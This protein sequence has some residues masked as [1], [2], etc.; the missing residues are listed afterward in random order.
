MLLGRL[1][2]MAQASGAMPAGG[3]A[4][5]ALPR[6]VPPSSRLSRNTSTRSMPTPEVAPRSMAVPWITYAP[7]RM[8]A[9]GDGLATSSVMFDCDEVVVVV[10]VV[11]VVEVLGVTTGAA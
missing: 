3:A 6:K 9:P 10:G 8:V 11:V 7:A 2:V 4:S 1:A 5:E